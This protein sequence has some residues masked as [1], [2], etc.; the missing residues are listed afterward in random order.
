MTAKARRDIT[1]WCPVKLCL[2][3]GRFVVLLRL[4]A[5]GSKTDPRWRILCYFKGWDG[6][7]YFVKGGIW[8][9]GNA[10]LHPKKR[11]AVRMAERGFPLKSQKPKEALDPFFSLD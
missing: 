8:G 4:P 7:P 11:F 9:R 10:A 1:I 5:F 6:N 2:C 3:C